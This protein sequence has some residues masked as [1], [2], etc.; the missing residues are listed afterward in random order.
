M[1]LRSAAA[2]AAISRLFICSANTA[3]TGFTAESACLHVLVAGSRKANLN[4]FHRTFFARARR[5]CCGSLKRAD[6][7]WLEFQKKGFCIFLSKIF[8][9]I[10]M[11]KMSLKCEMEQVKI[12]EV[13]RRHFSVCGWGEK[14]L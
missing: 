5:A 14:N 1:F 9:F 8:A 13:K 3:N 2:A 6:A 4:R 12:H 7:K 11:T 10:I